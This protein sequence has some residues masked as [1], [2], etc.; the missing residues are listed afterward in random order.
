MGFTKS[1]GGLIAARFFLGMFEGGLIGG[2]LVYLALFY[3]RHQLLY[4]IGL[5]ACAAPLS[6]AFGGL[7]ATGLSK[8]NY[9]GYK[10]TETSDLLST[11]P[12]LILI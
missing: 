7:L 9:G 4:R 8:I 10:G 11:A 1:Y 5:F 6:V 3:R 2:L 12:Q